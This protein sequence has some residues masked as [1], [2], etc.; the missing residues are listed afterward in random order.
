MRQR[1]FIRLRALLA[2][3][4]QWSGVTNQVIAHLFYEFDIN[5]GIG[6][7]I[8]TIAE[9]V[10][11]EHHLICGRMKAGHD[12]FASVTVVG[13]L[14]ER[15]IT[16]NRQLRETLDKIGATLVHIHGGPLATLGAKKLSK[17]RSLAVS[18][19][20]WPTL[21]KSPQ[22]LKWRDVWGTPAANPRVAITTAVAPAVVARQ[23]GAAV[24][25]SPD[26]NVATKLSRHGVS[27]NRYHA[28][29]RPNIRPTTLEVRNE[30]VLAGRAELS[31]GAD[32]LIEAVTLL[33]SRGVDVT[34]RIALLPGPHTNQILDL[35]APHEG[36]DVSVG[37][38]DLD[39]L[40]SGALAAV[41]PF[42]F[43]YTTSP[44]VLV[45]E[46]ALACGTPVIGTS[47][48]CLDAVA[49]ETCTLSVPVGD[50]LATAHAIEQL[51]TSPGMREAF[52]ANAILHTRSRWEKYGLAT[53]V[54]S[55]YK[56]C[57]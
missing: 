40:L 27:V 11:G 51:V 44:P 45:A 52:S 25:F 48:V 57:H 5:E 42:R 3:G 30:V 34:A 22:G 46:E 17:G 18:I 12:C 21:P 32:V 28:A 53:V 43:N 31:R 56:K 4:E 7:S 50:V 14:L 47:V 33:R 54:E 20:G 35:A 2:K 8:A 13:G 1:L 36:I 49:D 41:L 23:L 38:V 55:G 37:P 39:E 10:P 16:S 15:G 26:P 19:Y 24:V 29:T 6:R 9:T